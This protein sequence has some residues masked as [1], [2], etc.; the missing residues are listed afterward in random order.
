MFPAQPVKK[1]LDIFSL[2][3]L[4]LYLNLL[5]GH[6]VS[7]SLIQ[8]LFYIINDIKDFPV[9]CLNVILLLRFFS[10]T[11]SRT[12]L[13]VQMFNIFFMPVNHVYYIYIL[14][15]LLCI[16]AAYNPI[17]NNSIQNSTMQECQLNVIVYHTEIF[18]E[19]FQQYRE[20]SVRQYRE[21]RD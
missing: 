21:K 15:H 10:V 9:H 8:T 13:V 7:G 4:S 5:H 6:T 12:C 1:C 2:L 18:R 17:Q 19:R 16:Q 11:L 14:F 20:K 3:L